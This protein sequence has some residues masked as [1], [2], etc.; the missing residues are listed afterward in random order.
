MEMESNNDCLN[1]IDIMML[2]GI[3]KHTC[4]G[5]LG[6]LRDFITRMYN[7]NYIEEM[8]S[9]LAILSQ[10]NLIIKNFISKMRVVLENNI[11]S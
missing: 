1:F 5:N 11:I 3:E 4:I 7:K 9:V 10:T 2:R 8:A 6:D